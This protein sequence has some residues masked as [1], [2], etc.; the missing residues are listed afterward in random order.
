MPGT[1]PKMGKNAL[2]FSKHILKYEK[3]IEDFDHQRLGF[4]QETW[5]FSRINMGIPTIIV[6]TTL[7]NLGLNHPLSGYQTAW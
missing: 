4:H 1:T 7:G 3:N 6:T 2:D 5:V